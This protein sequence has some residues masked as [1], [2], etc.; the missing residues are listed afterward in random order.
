MVLESLVNPFTAVRKPWELFF[1][2]F[3]YNTIAIFLSLWIFE[4]H[5][6]LVM[7]FLTVIATVPLMYFTIKE[8]EE[9]DLREEKESVIMK[10]HA[11]VLVFLMFMFLG[12]MFSVAMWYIVLPSSI[13]VNLFSIQ[14]KTIESI[15]QQI[16]GD[17]ITSTTLFLKI[18]SNNL[19]VLMF[20]LLFAFFY[21]IGAI[22]ILTW[23]ATVIGVA[24]GN[25]VRVNISKF[26]SYFTIVPFAIMKYMTHGLVEI[27][28]Y[29]VGGLAGGIIS[30]A[31]IKHDFG[32]NKFEHVL[33]D[34]VDLILVAI[35]MLLFAGVV[36]VYITP[37]L[38]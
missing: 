9:F 15:N 31:V 22:F 4:A 19:K 20:C 17:A 6:S 14:T 1:I 36:E 37:V 32:T 30:I 11:K 7:V 12:M 13:H 3:L 16:T 35:L 33:L 8:E 29:F 27:A 10:Q 5:A 21:G 25:F 24:M 28:A 26:V 23:N 2:G 38:F 18:F 34:S